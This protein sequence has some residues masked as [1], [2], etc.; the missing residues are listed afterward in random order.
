MQ[1]IRTS[2]ILS[3][4]LAVAMVF[5][6]LPMTAFAED[7]GGT[8]GDSGGAASPG[9]LS[10]PGRAVT[11]ELDFTSMGDTDNLATDGW[12]WVQ[13]TKTLT[14]NG[15]DLSIDSDTVPAIKL[16][17]GSAI[18]L[19]GSNNVTNSGG[20]GISC[21]GSLEI[22][23]S[24]KL[25]I[26]AEFGIYAEN[27]VAISGGTVT[28]NDSWIGIYT[29]FGGVTIDGGT[30]TIDA[31]YDGISAD[32]VEISGGTVT[33]DVDDTGI[34]AH[35]NVTINGGTVKIDSYIFGILADN[36]F[37]ISGGEL[38]INADILGIS[39]D[40][41]DVTIKGGKLT[42]TAARFGISADTGNVTISGGSGTIHATAASGNE[43]S[44]GA[45][46]SITT[47]NVSV[48]GWGSSGYTVASAISSYI[49]N[50]YTL[51]TFVDADNPDT[52][53]VNIWF[54]KPDVTFTAQSSIDLQN[55]TDLVF[56]AND[57]SPLAG[58]DFSTVKFTTL[59]DPN[60]GNWLYEPEVSYANGTL[61][62]PKELLALHSAP[63]P[64][65]GGKPPLTPG[66]Y[67]AV[68]I[69]DAGSIGRFEYYAD[70][71][72]TDGGTTPS[73]SSSSSS[74]SSSRDSTGTDHTAVSSY[75]IEVPEARGMAKSAKENMLDYARSHRATITGIRKSSLL[76][77][78][79]AGLSYH[80][81]VMA[82]GA[83]QVRLYVDDPANATKDILV[84][85]YIKGADVDRVKAH[86]EKWFTNKLRVIHFDQQ[87]DFGQ[88]VRIAALID[89][90]G[91][92]T[93]SLHFYSYDKATNTYRRI[94]KPAYWIDKNGYLHFTTEYAGEIIISDGELTKK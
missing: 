93:A 29:N 31:D 76:V 52:P 46:D 81:D 48:K 26:D 3:L 15:L 90:T 64:A 18:V 56:V 68:I 55:P 59:S 14:L 4:L 36:D 86:F 12:K 87:E 88:P 77:L 78:A 70:F 27:D 82:N 40:T 43:L 65:G 94:E 28:V 37:T 60:G 49:Y 24:G 84:S 53:L 72:L 85:G 91:M 8:L 67:R 42:I 62:I 74:S 57:A 19:G 47:S 30:V 69:F 33:I 45:L 92:D 73:R 39:A 11:T 9:V 89:L 35:G 34:D 20:D 32:N 10:S 22:S 1:S 21:D 50:A 5:T 80:H 44:V 83:V 6:M 17:D 13:S 54:G 75:W 38:T 71:N 79:E 61:T 16:P 2:K 58:Y 63:S 23:G 66:T 25:T 7:G 51:S 41:G